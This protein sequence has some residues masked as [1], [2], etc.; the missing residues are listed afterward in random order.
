MKN[1]LQIGKISK[2]N[3]T[4]LKKNKLQRKA[5]KIVGKISGK[6]ILQKISE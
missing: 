3:S 4:I 5:K 1:K 6:K 2:N